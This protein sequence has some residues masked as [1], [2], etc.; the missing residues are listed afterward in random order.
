VVVF[1]EAREE[2]GIAEFDVLVPGIF[3][4]DIHPIPER[5]QEPG[6]LH[7]DVRFLLRARTT[8]FQISE[9]SLTLAWVPLAGIS[10]PSLLRLAEKA[11]QHL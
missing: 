10:E 9:E 11:Q 3:D 4:L 1:C 6:H 8:D 5:G 2:S 7:Y